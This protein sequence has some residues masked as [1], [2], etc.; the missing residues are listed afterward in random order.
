MKVFRIKLIKTLKKSKSKVIIKGNL[1]VL[2]KN[3]SR[4]E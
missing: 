1:V 3:K 2:K 4:I